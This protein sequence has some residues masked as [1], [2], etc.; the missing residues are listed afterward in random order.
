MTEKNAKKTPKKQTL[1]SL[2]KRFKNYESPMRDEISILTT[3]Q[4]IDDVDS[5]LKYEEV[6]IK[7]GLKKVDTTEADEA[8]EE[9]TRSLV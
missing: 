9:N 3:K 5:I 7:Y 8:E 1:N 4:I 2:E 6:R